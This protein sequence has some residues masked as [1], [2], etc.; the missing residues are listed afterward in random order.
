MPNSPALSPEDVPAMADESKHTD[1]EHHRRMGAVAGAA[2]E[3]AAEM[4]G[5]MGLPPSTIRN[6]MNASSMVILAIIA[7]AA[8]IWSRIDAKDDRHEYQLQ[9]QQ[10]AQLAEERR[11]EDRSDRQRLEDAFKTTLEKISAD[12]RENVRA[13]TE[14]VAVMR[15]VGESVKDASKEMKASSEAMIRVEK[16]LTAKKEQLDREP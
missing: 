9:V 3:T 7:T 15:G 4:A 2:V 6:Y 12:S 11:R 13:S 16:A 1:T 14:G 8:F 10:A 5:G